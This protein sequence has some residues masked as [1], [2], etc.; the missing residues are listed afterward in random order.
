M[1][2]RYAVIN[3][4]NIVINVISW[5]GQTNYNPGEGLTLIQSDTA[6]RGYIWDGTSFTNPNETIEEQEQQ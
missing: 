6:G 5:C 4:E 3:Q 1:I 2:K